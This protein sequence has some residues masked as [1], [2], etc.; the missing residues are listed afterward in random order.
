MVVRIL[1]IDRCGLNIRPKAPANPPG[2]GAQP[3]C[4]NPTETS[5]RPT[6]RT[7][8]GAEGAPTL[9]KGSSP[10]WLQPGLLEA[11]RQHLPAGERRQQRDRPAVQSEEN[12][13][14]DRSGGYFDCVQA[15]L[16]PTIISRPLAHDLAGSGQEG[17]VSPL[18]LERRSR[19]ARCEESGL[20]H[21]CWREEGGDG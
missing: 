19:G 6:A 12:R 21:G 14:R 18:G 8:L 1:N 3:P 7:G 10:R 9:Q 4:R 2:L 16:L 13:E 5:D 15:L 20:K 11:L 17:R